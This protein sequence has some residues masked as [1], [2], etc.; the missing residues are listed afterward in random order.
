MERIQFYPKG[1]NPKGKNY[2]FFAAHP[3]DKDR[4]FNTLYNEI[5]A[6][7]ENCAF[8]FDTQP[9]Q[10][11][12]DTVTADLNRMQLFLFPV[13]A[14]LLTTGDHA[15]HKLLS[16]AKQSNTS[17]IPILM[18]PG[19]EN[20][21]GS[22]FGDLQY[23]DR[24]TE[25]VTAI[26]FKEK[27]QR[28][29]KDIL[30]DKET[31]QKIREAFDAYIFLSYRKKDRALAAKLMKLIHEI[32]QMRDVAI[33][34]DEFLVPGEDF[35]GNIA[36]ALSKSDLFAMAVTPNLVNE[37]NY[38]LKEEYPKTKKAGKPVLPLQVAA[39]DSADFFEGFTNEEF[40]NELAASIDAY[41]G[42]L[43]GKA[44]LEGF[45]RLRHIT[46]A[47]NDDPMHNY[48]IG[49][50]YL[51]GID[52]EVDHKRA[53]EL[54]TAAAEKDCPDALAEM[55]NMY[56][57]GNGVPRD[58]PTA[59]RWTYRLIDYQKRNIAS[60]K[61]A[62]D[63]ITIHR[64][65]GVQ[66]GS[67]RKYTEERTA[68]L[69]TLS[70]I[71]RLKDMI[72]PNEI[73]RQ[74]MYTYEQLIGVCIKLWEPCEAYLE[75]ELD[76]ARKLETETNDLLAK[77]FI[78]SVLSHKSKLCKNQKQYDDSI[79]FAQQSL[80]ILEEIAR[81]EES[82]ETERQITGVLVN[83]GE[84]CS[85]HSDK[86]KQVSAGK[87]LIEAVDRKRKLAD[88]T[89]LDRDWE[90]LAASYNHLGGFY[91]DR[92]D[93]AHSIESYQQCISIHENLYREK[94]SLDYLILLQTS[95]HNF[96]VLLKDMG[97]PEEAE[98]VLQKVVNR[99]R[100][101][102]SQIT[103]A[104][105][106]SCNTMTYKELGLVY[107]DMGK[108]EKAEFW[109]KKAERE[110]RSVVNATAADEAKIALADLQIALGQ[111]YIRWYQRRLPGISAPNMVNPQ[112]TPAEVSN[113][114]FALDQGEL[115]LNSGLGNLLSVSAAQLIQQQH[116]SLM[117]CYRTLSDLFLIRKDTVAALHYAERALEIAES[118][119]DYT[120]AVRR[121]RA[122][123]YTQYALACDTQRKE[124]YFLK[125]IVIWESIAN[126]T[127]IS[128]DFYQWASVL[129]YMGSCAKEK[130]Y[131]HQAKGV[132]SRCN[133]SCKKQNLQKVI[134][135]ALK[136]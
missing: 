8:W 71:E 30:I 106:I 13:T 53:L 115:L 129:Y 47:Q 121:S 19:L 44:L 122:F 24:V 109:L 98:A 81:I 64:N 123:A 58:V 25:D 125:S 59:I 124:M 118:T 84:L 20:M 48:L 94:D 104:V 116:I 103:S 49:L 117:E 32:P 62:I 136:H 111:F 40:K 10:P 9:E 76:A 50:A 69:N 38:V 5:T 27:L 61:D 99:I 89:N 51:N 67:A 54:I 7:E 23:L 66:Y 95:C 43:L 96:A 82:A 31:A 72:S 132:L 15:I 11:W 52:V 92:G 97:H 101:H 85:I 21:Y 112:K 6:I 2:I 120:I 39:T 35:N 102:K 91:K 80:E 18:E 110:Q 60:E 90:Q 79:L 65:L 126:Q 113:R 108:M 107:E 70:E 87:Y 46:L 93:F 41:N 119:S 14:K 29:L 17:I 45:S 57:N 74:R 68:Y 86:E 22:V 63:S 34:Y 1:E 56:Q 127:K 134:I 28:F 100:A 88:R 16:Y 42:D 105:D 37:N 77:A 83:L 26:P 4:Y 78:A 36:Q 135:E 114:D 75:Q 55:A 133:A 128:D 12:D 130:N 73:L 33:W 3:D 131:L